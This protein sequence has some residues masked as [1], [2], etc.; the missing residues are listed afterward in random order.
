MPIVPVGAIILMPVKVAT[1]AFKQRCRY[2]RNELQLFY[3]ANKNELI[4]SAP[5]VAQKTENHFHVPHLYFDQ[6][7]K[8]TAIYV[9]KTNLFDFSAIQTFFFIILSVHLR[10]HLFTI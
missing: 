9:K 8:K 5:N 3:P 6:Y 4:C 2:V 1:D 7:W 10:L